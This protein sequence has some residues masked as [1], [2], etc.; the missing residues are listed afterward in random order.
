MQ[1][2]YLPFLFTQ[3]EDLEK[4]IQNVIEQDEELSRQIK[5]SVEQKKQLTTQKKSIWQRLV[6]YWQELCIR[7]YVGH[8]L[9]TSGFHMIHSVTSYQLR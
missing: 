1:S 8:L 6:I 2:P 5:V 4:K 9:F 7:F 3:V